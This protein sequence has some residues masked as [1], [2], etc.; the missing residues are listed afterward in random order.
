MA[1]A[2]FPLEFPLE[3]AADKVTNI[4]IVLSTL[5]FRCPLS[6]EFDEAT[7][8]ALADFQRN[9]ALDQSGQADT[10]TLAALERLRHTW[11]GKDFLN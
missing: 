4:Q 6:G 9:V 8:A 3:L 1:G 7:K 5:G 11:E 10:Q 2:E